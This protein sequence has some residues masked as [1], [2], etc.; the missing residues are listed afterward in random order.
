VFDNIPG[1]G[2]VFWQNLVNAVN[3]GNGVLRGP[4][5]LV[6]A[7]GGTMTSVP[8]AGTFGFASGIPGTDGASEITAATLVGIDVLPREGMYALRGQGCAIALLADADDATQW[9]VQTEFG[10]SEGV[11]MILTGPVGDNIAN[12]VT[13]KA[14]AG[15]DTYAAKLMFGDWVYWADQANAMT[16]LVSPQGFVAGRLANLS[17]EQSSLNKP[18]YGVIGTQKS[19]QPGGGTATTY[20]SADLSVLLG[21]GIDV[22]ANP[23]PGGNFWGVRGGH[24]SSSNAAVNGDNYTRLTNYIAYT[25]SAGMGAYVGELVNATL[26]QNIRGTLLAFLNGLLSQ[27]LLGS[28]DGSLPFAVVCDTS[29]N[30]QSRTALGYVQADVQVQY[31][32]INEKFIVNVQGGQ[33]VQV[34]V[35][36]LPG[37]N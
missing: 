33:T 9:G 25:L 24:N 8:V 35:Q 15:I 4:S 20:A 32:A 22:I 12:A 6:V 36:T 3:N 31:Q 34:S 23:Q 19:G 10:L 29:N 7:N 30:P 28:T 16:R 21:A 5:Q 26:F 1:T 14:E 18:L 11:Y 37:S 13:V 27:G 17:P 2:A